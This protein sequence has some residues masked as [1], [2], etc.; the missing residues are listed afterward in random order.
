MTEF[1]KTKPYV[2][3]IESL[4]FKDEEKGYFEGE[5]ISKILNLSEIEHEYYYIRT[6]VMLVI[7]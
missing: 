5:I 7:N 1:E 2:F 6:S 3:I 4:E